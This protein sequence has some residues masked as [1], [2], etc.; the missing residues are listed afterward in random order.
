MVIADINDEAPVFEA[1]E[2]CAQVTEF[3]EPRDT[4]TVLRATDAD[5]PDTP[6]GRLMFT[7]Q[8]GNEK[9]EG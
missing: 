1:R 8:S 2:G 5:D 3:H 9:G 6:N 4:V 7:I